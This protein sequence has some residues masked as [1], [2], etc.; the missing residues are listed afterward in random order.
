MAFSMRQPPYFSQALVD[1]GVRKAISRGEHLARLLPRSVG[2][3]LPIR[4]GR[5]KRDRP[6]QLHRL[7]MTMKLAVF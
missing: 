5:G 4:K 2:P 1:A 6:D 3:H 7:E